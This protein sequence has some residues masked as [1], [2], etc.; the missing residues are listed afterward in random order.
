MTLYEISKEYKEFLTAVE[1][2]EIPEEAIGDTLDGLSGTFEMKAD[3]TACMIK[4]LLIEAYGMKCEE[5]SLT[6]RRKAKERQAEALKAYLTTAMIETGKRK[7]ETARNKLSFR[8]STSLYIEDEAEFAKEHPELC[9]QEMK[10]SII[11]REVSDRI[12]AGEVF[13]GA[14]LKENQKLQIK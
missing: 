4:E 1:S 10:I 9:K 3:N 13:A 2:G 5:E 8:K 7:I 11:K 12:K 6:E 14:E